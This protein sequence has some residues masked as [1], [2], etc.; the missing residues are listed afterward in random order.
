M[1]L[2]Q[3]RTTQ[4]RTNNV[5]LYSSRL[6]TG[7]HAAVV[8]GIHTR[9]I[10]HNNDTPRNV[11]TRCVR[12]K[13]THARKYARTSKHR[14]NPGMSPRLACRFVTPVKVKTKSINKYGDKRTCVRCFLCRET[15]FITYN[16]LA[17]V[18]ANF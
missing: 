14:M 4:S 16:Y 9:N 7:R 6:Q 2:R 17:F 11:Q 8:F 3:R 18:P 1:T 12:N 15:H 13:H 5:R 10:P